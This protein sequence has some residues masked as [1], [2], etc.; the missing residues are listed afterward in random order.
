MTTTRLPETAEL[1]D[2]ISAHPGLDEIVPLPFDQ[3]QLQMFAGQISSIADPDGVVRSTDEQIGGQF[4][5]GPLKIADFLLWLG[6]LGLVGSTVDGFPL[7]GGDEIE[8]QIIDEPADLDV[9]VLDESPAP[10]TRNPKH[11]GDY[12]AAVMNDPGLPHMALLAAVAINHRCFK[13]GELFA[14]NDQIAEWMHLGK[15]GRKRVPGYLETL[16]ERG[17]L[18]WIGKYRRTDRYRLA[19]PV[20]P[21]GDD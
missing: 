8:P 12:R 19:I 6:K 15:S 21:L 16:V 10:E 17:Y 1:A 3:S 4:G 20:V 5:W 9:V 14:G 13:T 11:E 2:L 18:V 7:I